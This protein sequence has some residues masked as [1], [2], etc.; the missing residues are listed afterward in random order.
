MTFLCS[1]GVI[2][3]GGATGIGRGIAVSFAEKSYNVLVVDVL[4]KRDG[5]TADP[6]NLCESNLHGPS[7]EP[8]QIAWRTTF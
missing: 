4:S 5:P 3:T 8:L 2:V 7:L 6:R 1:P